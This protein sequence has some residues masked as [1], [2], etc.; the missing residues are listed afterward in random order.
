M[1]STGSESHSLTMLV[2]LIPPREVSHPI[3]LDAVAADGP[4]VLHVP[5]P[6]PHALK[7]AECRDG[8]PVWQIPAKTTEMS[9]I[10]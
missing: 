2:Q 6:Y 8:V 1:Y 10:C 3:V 5:T 9:S 4:H 7:Y